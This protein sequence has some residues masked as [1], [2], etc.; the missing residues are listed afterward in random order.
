M[1]AF[2]IGFGALILGGVL[3]GVLARVIS[4]RAALFLSLGLLGVFV[5][6]MVRRQLSEGWDAIGYFV[7]AVFYVAPACVGSGLVGL[8]A[9]WGSRRR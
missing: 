9:M 1:E 8:L 4:P 7:L 3:G 6:L 5:I 2:A